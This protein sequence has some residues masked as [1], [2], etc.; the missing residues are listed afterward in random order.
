M[1]GRS[2]VSGLVWCQNHRP[3]DCL[4]PN[5]STCDDATSHGKG[6]FVDV[7][8]VKDSEVQRGSQILQCPY[9]VAWVLESREA[10]PAAVSQRGC[11][12]GRRVRET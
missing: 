7:V 5:P 3:Q 6:D 9:L 2:D 10:F 12:F 11:D 8:K 4:C 1:E